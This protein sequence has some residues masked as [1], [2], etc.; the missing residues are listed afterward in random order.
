MIKYL[1]LSL[2]NS[3]SCSKILK[4]AKTDISNNTYVRL[5]NLR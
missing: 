2:K 4:M 5:C 1:C 3:I